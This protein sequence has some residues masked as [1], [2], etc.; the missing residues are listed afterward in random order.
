VVERLVKL[1]PFH[2]SPTPVLSDAPRLKVTNQGPWQ[3][4][5][6]TAH[7]A[8]DFQT[9]GFETFLTKAVAAAIAEKDGGKLKKASEL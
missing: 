9:P 6:F 1:V 8:D 5:T 2:E 3:E 7:S 4:I